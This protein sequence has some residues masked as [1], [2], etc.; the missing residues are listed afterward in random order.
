MTEAAST[1]SDHSGD[2]PTAVVGWLEA[3]LVGKVTRKERFVARREGWLV[4]VD[5][6]DG[7]TLE[8]F[9]RLERFANGKMKQPSCQVRRETAVIAALHAYGPQSA[10]HPAST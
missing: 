7:G 9:L 8:G 4:D 10:S 6:A 2:L 3:A 1:T 5:C